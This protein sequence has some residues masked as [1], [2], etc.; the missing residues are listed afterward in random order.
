M[1]NSPTYSTVMLAFLALGS[2][3]VTVPVSG[4]S[5][6]YVAAVK[7]PL[8]RSPERNAEFTVVGNVLTST[9]YTRSMSVFVGC[10]MCMPTLTELALFRVHPVMKMFDDGIFSV[11]DTTSR[12]HALS[13]VVTSGIPAAP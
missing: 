5:T 1:V 7:H 11:A 3:A 9:L 4:G 8:V 13:W 2:M 12:K 6:A 10:T